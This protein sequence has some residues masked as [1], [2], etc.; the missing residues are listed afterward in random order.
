MIMAFT[1]DNRPHTI[2]DL[3]A[4]TGTVANG[5]TSTDLSAFMSE[6]LMATVAP[7]APAAAPLELSI[8]GT[9]VVHADPGVA[10]GGK[11]FALGKR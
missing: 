3:I 7:L 1:S 5:D 6:I 4:I 2:G 11:L 8:N 10:A 9:T